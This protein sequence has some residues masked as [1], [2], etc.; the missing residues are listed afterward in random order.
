MGY[1]TGKQVIFPLW[2]RPPARRAYASE[3]GPRPARHRSRSGEAGG[4]I[5]LRLRLP[6]DHRSIFTLRAKLNY[7][8]ST[9]GWF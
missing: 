2:Q 6:E 4:G 5:L 8:T 1:L 7:T 3:R 9:A